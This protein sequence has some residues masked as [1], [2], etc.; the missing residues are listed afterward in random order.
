[1]II[2][3]GSCAA[4]TLIAHIGLQKQGW[5][6]DRLFLVL[7]SALP[8]IL[9]AAFR[10][11][12]GQD[13][14]YT[15]VPYFEAVQ[16]GML[17]H[18][19]RLEILYHWLNQAVTWLGGDSFWV[20]AFCAIVFYL[21]VYA[22]IID[23]SPASE[24]SVILLT[25]MGYVF[26]FFNAMRQMVGVGILFYS[27][28]YVRQRRFLLFLLCVALAA[29]FHRANGVFLLVY[30]FPRLR[31][32][33]WMALVSTAVIMIL[34]EIIV[35][36]TK[37][38]ISLTQYRIYIASVYDTG[39]TAYIHLAINAVLTVFYSVLYR[40]DEQYQLYYNLQL[41]ALWVTIF[42]GKIVLSLRMLWMFGMPSVIS[43]PIA[44][45]SI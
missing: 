15:Y 2:F 8:M 16:E 43:L 45:Q 5:R 1:M 24:L 11:D 18:Y 42:S 30:F 3:I 6:K 7:F 10:Y 13:Y 37:H 19:G 17:P 21:L 4:S 26:V 40:D 9:V 36:F 27:L 12:V 25:C 39:Q 28:R 41:M 34:S 29:G 31:I 33:P 35:L 22:Q 14:L 32:R 23:E 44:L 20:F 38:L